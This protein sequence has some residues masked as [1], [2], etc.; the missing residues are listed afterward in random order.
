M[1]KGFKD[2]LMRGNVVDLAVAVVIGTAFAKVVE[3]FVT[4]IMDLVG[5]LGGT[6]DFSSF[7]P[8]G[9]AIGGFL[10]ALVGFLVVAA[11]VYFMVV[12]PMNLL[13]ERR[14]SGVEPEPEA[15]SEEII[16]LQE[17]RDALRVR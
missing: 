7:K 2:F 4:V 13:A 8:G 9:V 17:I 10:T 5:K 6:P 1:I 12:V 15:P 16:V 14:K 11:A 3:S